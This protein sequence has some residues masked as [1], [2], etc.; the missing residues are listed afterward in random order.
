[1][2][3]VLFGVLSA[4]SFSLN[5]IA[6]RRGVL[7]ASATQGMYITVI[8]G[9]PLFA[10]SALVTGQ[11]FDISRVTGMAWLYLPAAGIVHFNI[12][13]YGNYQTVRYIGANAST[14]FRSL[15]PLFAVSMS[16]L[17]LDDSVTLLKGFG[18]ALVILAPLIMIQWK[19]RA[20]A[21]AATS[22]PSGG[23]ATAPAEA[24]ADAAQGAPQS[25]ATVTYNWRKGIL[26]AFIASLAYGTSPL[27]VKAGL[28]ESGLS[29]L[30]GTI[31]YVA[32]SMVLILALGLPGRL[33]FVMGMPRGAI[34]YFI[35]GGLAVFFAQMFRYVGLAIAPVS[36]MTPLQQTGSVWTVVFSFIFNRNTELFG[37]RIYAAILF[38]TLGALALIWPQ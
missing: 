1:M 3:G 7:L 23:A 31:S 12:G 19:R 9:V 15:T 35:Y 17:F 30:G 18:I 33:A 36:V 13:R 8:G 34:K 32:A 16:I 29:L 24:G 37:P 27:L 6:V 25:A 22:P 20:P 4:A 26:W 21:P 38:S 14:P 10:I 2:L 5:M 11:I 28:Q